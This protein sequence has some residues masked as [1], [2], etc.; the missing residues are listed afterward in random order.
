MPARMTSIATR[1]GAVLALVAA[2][3]SAVRGAD[4]L[5]LLFPQPASAAT[6]AST[7]PARVAIEVI[8]AGIAHIL[9]EL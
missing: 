1:A 3:L 9:G 8:R 4:A 2:Q 6:R 7:A 5:R